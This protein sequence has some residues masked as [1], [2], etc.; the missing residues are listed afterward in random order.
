MTL[1]PEDWGFTTDRD[2]ALRIGGFAAEFLARRFGTPLHAVDLDRLRERA[3]RFRTA[4]ESAYPAPTSTHYALKCNNTPG[5]VDAVLGEG[6]RLEV[7]TLYEWTLALR[8]GV[9]P[10]EI[11]VNGPFKGELVETAVSSGAGYIVADGPRDLELIEAA[12]GRRGSQAKILLRVNPDCVPRGMNRAT[13][14]GS[15]KGSVFGFDLRSGEVDAAIRKVAG[16]P[17]LVYGGLHAH[18]GTGIRRPED[19]ERPIELLVACAD[20]ARRAGLPPGVLDLGGGFGVATSREFKTSEFLLYQAIGRLPSPPDAARFPSVERFA[21]AMSRAVGRHCARRGLPIPP[22]LL[23]PGRAIVSQAGALLLTVG[24]IKRRRGATTW[25]IADGGAGTVAFP[26]YYE[27]HE[28]L[29]CRAPR[30]ARPSRYTIVG[31][32]CFSADWICRN[33]RMPP[34][35]EGDV[36]AVCDAGAYFTVQESNFGFPRPAIVAI[37]GGRI[38]ELRRRESFDDMVRRDAAWECSRVG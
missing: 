35:E 30:A 5:I 1:R 10:V 24:S 13:A 6:L 9:A 27:Y 25:V 28:I 16:A 36:L 18:V 33:K 11:V 2:G 29:L 14:T 19:Y 31:P 32:A 38:R 20:R 3:R 34:L 17:R 15:R 22:L 8:L 23:E 7:G 26:L 37:E 4:F 21:E 12:A